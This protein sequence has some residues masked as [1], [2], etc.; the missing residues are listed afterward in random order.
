MLVLKRA[1]N[2]KNIYLTHGFVLSMQY[3]QV[4]LTKFTAM[5][6]LMIWGYF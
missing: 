4:N 2:G 1:F 3:V 6:R 5:S